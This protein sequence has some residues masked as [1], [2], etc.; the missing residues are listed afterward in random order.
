ML[1]KYE[2]GHGEVVGLNIPADT[3]KDFA[4]E[5]FSLYGADN[6]RPDKGDRGNYLLI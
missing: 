5:Y 2:T 6:E 3:L 4:T 1:T